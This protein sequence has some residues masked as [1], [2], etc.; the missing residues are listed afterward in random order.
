MDTLKIMVKHVKTKFE[1]LTKCITGFPLIAGSTPGFN[2]GV[3]YK[4]ES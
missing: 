1:I 4:S 3:P 2:G